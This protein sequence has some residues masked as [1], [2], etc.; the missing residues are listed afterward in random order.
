[1]WSVLL[2][3]RSAEWLENTCSR[4]TYQLDT[5]K[6]NILDSLFFY[7]SDLLTLLNFAWVTSSQ[8][9]RYMPFQINYDIH[10]FCWGSK[11]G[12]GSSF[13]HCHLP[14]ICKGTFTFPLQP[15]QY[16]FQEWMVS[17][18]VSCVQGHVSSWLFLQCYTKMF[19]EN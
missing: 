13:F 12:D 19:L 8:S 9:K 2:P 14:W 11:G 16:Q 7:C 6:Q 4:R 3:I 1:V 5:K 15:W 17:Q 18:P 10:G